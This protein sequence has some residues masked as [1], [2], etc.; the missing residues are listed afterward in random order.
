MAPRRP[1]PPSGS[2]PST[3]LRDILLALPLGLAAAILVWIGDMH[4]THRDWLT[5]L[6]TFGFGMLFTGLAVRQLR[7]AGLVR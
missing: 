5:G 4:L 7:R 6:V 2:P 1:E 3:R